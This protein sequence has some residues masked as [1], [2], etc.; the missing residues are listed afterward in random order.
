M[1]SQEEKIRVNA[2]IPKSLY[3]FVCSEYEN[4]SQAINEGLEKLRK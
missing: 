1:T 4:V 3:D 2:R